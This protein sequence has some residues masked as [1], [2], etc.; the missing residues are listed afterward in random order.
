MVSANFPVKKLKCKE[1]RHLYEVSW[2]LGVQLALEASPPASR[3]RSLSK[4]RRGSIL[5]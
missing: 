3:P 4:G 5:S 2:P 1:D